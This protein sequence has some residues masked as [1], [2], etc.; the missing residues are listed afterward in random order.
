MRGRGASKNGLGRKPGPWWSGE[1][2]LGCPWFQA[3]LH[4]SMAP[5][6]FCPVTIWIASTVQKIEFGKGTSKKSEQYVEKVEKRKRR[7]LKNKNMEKEV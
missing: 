7:K 3:S 5:L 4:P 2:F 1:N 6:N